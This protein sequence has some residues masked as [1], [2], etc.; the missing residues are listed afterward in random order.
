MNE[1][2]DISNEERALRLAEYLE[3][4]SSDSSVAEFI[5]TAQPEK[6]SEEIPTME[7]E[8]SMIAV[9]HLLSGENISPE[10]IFAVEAIV[11]KEKRPSHKVLDGKFDPFPGDYLYLTEN[12]SVK[13]NIR[14]AF[15]SIG[16]IDTPDRS[17]YGGTGFVVGK[18]LVMTNRHVAQIFTRGVGEENVSIFLKNS[19]IDFREAPINQ[20]DGFR[21]TSCVM[22]HPYWDMALFKAD[23]PDLDPLTL[24]V[25]PYSELRDQGQDIVVVGYPAEDSSRNARDAQH[26]YF[27]NDFEIKRVAPGKVSSQKRA[28]SSRWLNT[29]VAAL[30]HDA[31]TLGGN[32]GSAVINVDNGQVAALHFAGRYLIENYAVPGHELARD[33]RIIDAGVTFDTS[34]GMPTEYIPLRQYWKNADPKTVHPEKQGQ[35]VIFDM[36]TTKTNTHGNEVTFEIPLRVTVSIDIGDGPSPASI[37]GGDNSGDGDALSAESTG[38]GYDP[39]FLSQKV[40]TPWL[41]DDEFEDAFKLG[42]SHLIPYTHFSVCQSKSRTLPRFVAWNIDGAN[43]KTLSRKN[44]PFIRDSRVPDQFQAGNELYKNNPY[45]RGH[46]ARRVDLNWGPLA[47]AKA[48]N[49]DSFFFTNM[50]PQHEKFNQ[51]KR[52]GLWGRVEN[53]ILEDIEVED[54]RVSVM[55]GPIFHE[56]DPVYRGVQIPRDFWKLVAFKDTEDNQFKVTALILSQ[57]ELIPTETLELD[58]F[59]L[60]KASLSKLEKATGLIFDHLKQFDTFAG[61]QEAV[62]GSGLKEVLGRDDLTS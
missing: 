17:I 28:I 57:A 26:K 1:T 34:N 37:S 46:V 55:A 53:A 29:A 49:R 47:E 35:A 48:A 36:K 30:T 27:G 10:D 33:P 38:D 25:V 5:S 51:S 18:N 3:T 45:D 12:K 14:K 4:I 11:H 61:N 31:S 20:P 56:D 43:M 40:A 16:R 15:P 54:L 8:R 62:S 41:E 24:S 60:Y 50:C 2:E 21:L 39:N 44:I 6:L 32:S 13:K 52:H 23:L 19:E 58:A 22:I 9:E 59:N 42:G 7:A